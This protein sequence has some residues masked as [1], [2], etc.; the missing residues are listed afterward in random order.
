MSKRLALL[1]VILLLF[2]VCVTS[3]LATQTAKAQDEPVNEAKPKSPVMRF[4]YVRSASA[5]GVMINRA[6]VP[7]GWFVS[8]TLNVGEAAGY[9]MTFVPD[10]NH[11]WDGASIE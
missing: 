8:G 4:E 9:G 1:G 6:K 11:D 5:D 10:P 3:I 7:G 2:A